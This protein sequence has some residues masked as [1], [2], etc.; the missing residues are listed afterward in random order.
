MRR[1][2]RRCGGKNL[3]FDTDNSINTAIRKIRHASGD[4]AGNPQYVETVLG[5]GYRFKGQTVD[6]PRDRPRADRSPS[7]LASCS[8]FFPSKT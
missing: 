2:S 5:R 8:R 6:A 1:L 4:D 7:D 3:Y